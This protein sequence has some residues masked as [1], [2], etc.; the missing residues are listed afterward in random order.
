[1]AS[2]MVFAQSRT[3]DFLDGVIIG[4]L[5]FYYTCF[6]CIQTCNF[7]S[8]HTLRHTH[9][10]NFYRLEQ[11]LI[12]L[13]LALTKSMLRQKIKM[14]EVWTSC[15]FVKLYKTIW[16]NQ[17]LKSK[18]SML[19]FITLH[20]TRGPWTATLALI[21]VDKIKKKHYIEITLKILMASGNILC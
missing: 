19:W 21:K 9:A 7:L 17:W 1:M 20:I 14:M 13:L 3:I 16:E 12:L 18:S 8:N 10:Q 5:C 4:Q 11:W 15:R 6:S 2:S